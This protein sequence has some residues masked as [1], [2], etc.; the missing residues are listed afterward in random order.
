MKSA[1]S[2]TVYLLSAATCSAC[3]WLLLRGFL[4]N[5][6]RLL[7]WSGLCFA[8]LALE[9]LVLFLDVMIFPEVNLSLLRR[10]TALTGLALLLFG[11]VWDSE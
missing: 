4:R 9:N 5:R 3:A 8:G 6:L 7:L 2:I 10:L 11:L 1:V